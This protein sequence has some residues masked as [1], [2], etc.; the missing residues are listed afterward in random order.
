MA[1]TVEDEI[2]APAFRLVNADTLEEP[3]KASLEGDLMGRAIH[4]PF[5]PEDEGRNLW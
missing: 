4:S 5:I 2:S 3:M 1:Q